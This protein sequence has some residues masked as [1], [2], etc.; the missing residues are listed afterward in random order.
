MYI[1]NELGMI[2]GHFIIVVKYTPIDFESS[3]FVE[4]ISIR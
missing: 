4:Y 2:S 1:I 3:Q